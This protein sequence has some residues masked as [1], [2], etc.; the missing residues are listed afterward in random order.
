MYQLNNPNRKAMQ[1]C[2]H[3]LLLWEFARQ[4]WPVN[5]LFAAEQLF[6]ET[7]ELKKF[8]HTLQTAD[9]AVLFLEE[10]LSRKWCSRFF[11]VDNQAW[12]CCI[13]RECKAAVKGLDKLFCFVCVDAYTAT[14]Q[15]VLACMLFRWGMKISQMHWDGVNFNSKQYRTAWWLTIHCTSWGD[16][17]ECCFKAQSSNLE[18]HFSLKR[19]KRDVRDLSFELSKMS[20]RVELAVPCNHP[21]GTWESLFWAAPH[22]ETSEDLALSTCFN[23]SWSHP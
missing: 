10:Y 11:L 17:F 22:S 12:I 3:L 5:S 7:K 16:I 19:G 14:T 21:A 18:R 15:T 8:V 2:Q 13:R 1:N 4:A 20:P 23:T 6:A 9:Q